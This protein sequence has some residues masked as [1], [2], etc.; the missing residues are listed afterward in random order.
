MKQPS[1]NFAVSSTDKGSEVTFFLLE[2]YLSVRFV[3]PLGVFD[4]QG[5]ES[6]TRKLGCNFTK[7]TF[8][9]WSSSDK[10]G[11]PPR[12]HISDPA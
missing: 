2:D 8:Q 5:L 6:T 9:L 4:L 7:V 3:F 11:Q 10:S 1:L 12:A